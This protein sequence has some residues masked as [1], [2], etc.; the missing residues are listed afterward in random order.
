MKDF[1]DKVVLREKNDGDN[2]LYRNAAA[3]AAEIPWR[4]TQ[5]L[6]KI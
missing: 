1:R 4:H 3:K 2:D 5:I 6:H